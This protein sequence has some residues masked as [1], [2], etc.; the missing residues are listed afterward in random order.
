M[1]RPHSVGV[2]A[3]VPFVVCV[4][5]TA[6]AHVAGAE[7]LSDHRH[8]RGD[9]SWSILGTAA[10][11]LLGGNP[12]CSAP[13]GEK[14]DRWDMAGSTYNYCYAGCHMDWMLENSDKLNL[15]AYAGILY[16]AK[17]SAALLTQCLCVFPLM[18]H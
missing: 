5:T 7:L 6:P 3:L 2:V 12:G 18:V 10:G 9:D 16:T 13:V 1:C 4:L 14:W 17:L 8:R 11:E 15:S